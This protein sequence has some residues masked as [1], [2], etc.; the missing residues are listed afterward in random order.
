MDAT[1]RLFARQARIGLIVELLAGDD[2]SLNSGGGQMDSEI[3]ENLTS[4]GMVGE[5][6]AIEED[7]ALH[8]SVASQGGGARA[9]VL[10][11]SRYRIVARHLH[12]DRSTHDL[13]QDANATGI[14]KAIQDAELFG[15]RTRDETYF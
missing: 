13:E 11:S 5:E 7:D 2:M 12:W 10:S 15:K 6:E 9:K 8:L 3:S 14:V 1:H 4:R